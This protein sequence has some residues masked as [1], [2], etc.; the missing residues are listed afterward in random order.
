MRNAWYH[1]IEDSPCIA[2]RAIAVHDD[3]VELL[4]T[5]TCLTSLY[6]AMSSTKVA[7]SR[8]WWLTGVSEHDRSNSF[9]IFALSISTCIM[10]WE[11]LQALKSYSSGRELIACSLLARAQLSVVLITITTSYSVFV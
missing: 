7:P 8:C 10:W 5:L 9:S 11:A 6:I 1:A 3:A 4:P 2:Y